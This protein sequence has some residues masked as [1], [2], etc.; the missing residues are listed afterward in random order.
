MSTV[1]LTARKVEAIRRNPPKVGQVDFFDDAVKGFGLRVSPNG[2][3]SWILMYRMPGD[4]RKRRYTFEAPYP[5]LGLADARDYAKDHLRRI[6]KGKDP[7]AEKKANR[8]AGTFAELAD[9]YVEQYAKRRKKSWSKDR[10]IIDHDLNP[11]W[12]DRK[13]ESITRQ[14]GFV[15]RRFF[16]PHN[17]IPAG[18]DILPAL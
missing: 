7:A 2:R 9:L 3:I 16:H 18:L 17:E 11:W 1:N 4:A 5:A 6:A 8:K 14:G 15:L 12:R 10:K 13:A